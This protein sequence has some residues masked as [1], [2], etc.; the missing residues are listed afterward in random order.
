[1]IRRRTI[2]A[3]A[4]MAIKDMTHEEALGVLPRLRE[5]A[6]RANARVHKAIDRVAQTDEGPTHV[7]VHGDHSVVNVSGRE[8]SVRFLSDLHIPLEHVQDVEADPEIEH[9][10]W[11]G[12]EYLGSTCRGSGSMTCMVVEIRPS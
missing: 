12:G 9:T 6:A 2:S 8:W 3:E 7:I 11:R 5:E 4:N 1:M 10:L